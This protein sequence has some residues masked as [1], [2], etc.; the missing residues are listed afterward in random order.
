MATYRALLIPGM[1]ASFVPGTKATM[2]NKTKN[3]LL[4]GSLHS[5]WG[6]GGGAVQKL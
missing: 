1:N 5:S 6:G 3:F 2:I 4:A